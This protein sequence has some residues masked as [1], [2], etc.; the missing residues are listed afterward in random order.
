MDLGHLLTW[1]NIAILLGGVVGTKIV[2]YLAGWVDGHAEVFVKKE[3]EQLRAKMNE[4]SVLGQIGADDAVV[5]ILEAAIP[6]VLHE[7]TTDIAAALA[8]GKIDA[9]EWKDIGAKLWA[10]AKDHIQGGKNDYLANSSFDDGAAIASIVAKRFF[11]KQKLQ[12][13]GVITDPARTE[14]K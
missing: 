8:D 5:D 11:I 4:N 9:V 12:K 13:D 14:T 3:L 2:A 1:Q 10:K 7:A 6:E